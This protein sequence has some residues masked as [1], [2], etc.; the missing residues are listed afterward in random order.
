MLSQCGLANWGGCS[1]NCMHDVQ[2]VYDVVPVIFFNITNS[3]IHVQYYIVAQIK[4][5]IQSAFCRFLLTIRKKALLKSIISKKI[6][7]D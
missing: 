3:H 5:K 1:K 2:R 4:I 7:S 6:I